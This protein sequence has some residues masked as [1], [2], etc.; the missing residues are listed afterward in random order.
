MRWTPYESTSNHSSHE[1][2]HYGST[3]RFRQLLASDLKALLSEHRT[4]LAQH[5]EEH[6]GRIIKAAGD[7]YW[8]EFAYAPGQHPR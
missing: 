8:L 2:R 5:A 3:S 7:G 4:F 6:G 1:D